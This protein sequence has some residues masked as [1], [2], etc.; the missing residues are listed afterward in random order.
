MLLGQVK[1]LS[2]RDMFAGFI[3]FRLRWE[4]NVANPLEWHVV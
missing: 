4:R 3:D 1:A 2:K